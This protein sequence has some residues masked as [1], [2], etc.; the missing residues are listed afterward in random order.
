MEDIKAYQAQLEKNKITA[1]GL[2]PCLRCNLESKFFKIHAYRERRFLLIIAMF[3]ESIL[4]SLVRFRCTRCG[5]TFT[6]YPDFALAGK[7]YTRQTIES[8]SH[9]YVENTQQTYKTAAITHD[10]TPTYS[11]GDRVLAPS[12]I[13]HWISTLACLVTSCQNTDKKSFPGI[14]RKKY[15]SPE[16]KTCLLKCRNFFKLNPLKTV[17]HRL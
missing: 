16:R 10:G 11:E 5:K 3:V 8:F 7:H 12:T 14:A 1:D 15:R 6:Y 2:A 9:A 17:F 4:C 13:Y